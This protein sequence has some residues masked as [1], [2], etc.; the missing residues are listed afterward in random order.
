[1]ANTLYTKFLEQM[2]LGNIDWS[3][4]VVRAM[5]ERSTS[6]YS[7]DKDHEDRGDLASFV[8]ITASGY[9]RANIPSAGVE[10]DHA[11]DRIE[12]DG[13]SI[14]FGSIASGQTV[15]AM[16]VYIQTG[17]DDTTPNDDT[18]VVYIDTDS[19]A[20]LPKATGGGAF[21]VNPNSEGLIQGAQ[22]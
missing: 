3:T 12:L 22:A 2:A 4:A 5:L 1:M 17:G 13:G 16:V 20:Q 9:A 8:E 14:G 6:T 18:L 15:K 11:N 10:L 21:N 7:V 19:G